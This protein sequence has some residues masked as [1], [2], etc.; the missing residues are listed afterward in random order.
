METILHYVHQILHPDLPAL[1]ADYGIWIYAILFLIIFAET[2]LVVTPFLPG[3]SLLFAVGAMAAQGLNMWI[4]VPLLIFA[5]VLGD[6]VNY[7]IGKWMGP[8]VFTRE[9]GKF[10]RKDHLIKA[11]NFYVKYGPRAIILAR[12]APII[13]TFAPFVAGIG[14]MEYPKFFTYN[15]IGGAA[16]ISIFLAA[17]HFFGQIEI[18][19][20]NM[21][22][23]AIMIVIISLIPVAWE[24]LAA[25]MNKK[26]ESPLEGA[27]G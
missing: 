27:V 20:K 2:G 1:F 14:Q 16:W 15:V 3:D 8:K 11:Q 22:L 25:K 24:I 12:F 13:R 10:L 4:L 23:V 17:G 18:V 6:A 21:E 9:D 26:N 7:S 5:A 19:K